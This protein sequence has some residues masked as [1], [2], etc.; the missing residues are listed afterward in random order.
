MTRIQPKQ[1][2]IKRVHSPKPNPSAEV[3]PK[4][5][6]M[7]FVELI[8]LKV[9]AFKKETCE[10][11]DLKDTDVKPKQGVDFVRTNVLLQGSAAKT[12]KRRF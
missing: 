4:K 3:A 11:F 10:E 2:E 12:I 6:P 9:K 7:L 8:P 5:D 1:F